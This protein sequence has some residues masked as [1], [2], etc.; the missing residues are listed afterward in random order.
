M[1]KLTAVLP[2]ILITI[3]VIVA[4]TLFAAAP[5][6]LWATWIAWGCIG[7]AVL[8]LFIQIFLGNPKRK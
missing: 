3:A 4:I 6:T 7:L 5:N 2:T 1:S 8:C